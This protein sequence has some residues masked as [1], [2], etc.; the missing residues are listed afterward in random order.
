MMFGCNHP[1]VVGPLSLPV[2]KISLTLFLLAIPT[3]LAAGSGSGGIQSPAQPNEISI[4]IAEDAHRL[5]KLGASELRSYLKRLYGADVE[6]RSQMP[7]GNGS[8]FLIGSPG[9]N[10]VLEKWLPE[11]PQLSDQGL[12]LRRVQLEG[13][14][15]VVV[16]GGSPL[17]T[18]WSVYELLEKL[19]VRYLLWGDLLPEGS[20][21]FQLPD[22]DELKE[23][24]FRAR[25]F[26][27]KRVR[28]GQR[29]VHGI[30]RLARD[31][32]MKT[33]ILS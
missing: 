11:W 3:L 18:L 29:Y 21:E 8:V 17:A 10:A 9:T 19:G 31:F 15:A 5:E 27:G 1:Q 20:G 2:R 32:G 6:L 30:L 13:R 7:P 16:G 23:P 22:I 26:R 25:A 4:I 33:G 12:L 24:L 28:A 14:S